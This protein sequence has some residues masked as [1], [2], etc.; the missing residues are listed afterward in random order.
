MANEIKDKFSTSDALTITIASLAD[1]GTGSAGRQST[2]VNNATTRYQDI[3]LFVKFRNHLTV[4][5]TISSVL[6]VYLIRDDLDGVT[7]HRTDNAGAADAALT[8]ENAT[9]IGVIRNKL[10]PVA[11][12][13][14][15][16]EFLI[17]RPGPQWGIAVVN[18]TGQTLAVI[19]AGPDH[20]ARWIGLNPEVQ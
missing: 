18:R 13:I 6:E 10:V 9:L 8:I 17:H 15:Y 4:A 2:L 16:G 12:D 1:A 14:R 5:A 19:G 11:G 20:W 3:L 7:P